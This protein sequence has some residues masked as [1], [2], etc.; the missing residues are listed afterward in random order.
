MSEAELKEIKEKSEKQ[1]AK[2]GVKNPLRI[3]YALGASLVEAELKV[4]GMQV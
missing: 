1:L 4:R 2:L 3:I